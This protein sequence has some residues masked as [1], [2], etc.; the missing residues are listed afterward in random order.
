[1]PSAIGRSNAGPSFLRLAGARFTITRFAGLG[2]EDAYNVDAQGIGVWLVPRSG[3]KLGVRSHAGCAGAGAA[4]YLV[5]AAQR[6]AN[7]QRRRWGRKQERMMN[8]A[9]GDGRAE[10]QRRLIQRS[11]DEEEFRRRLLD[12]PKATIEQEL[13]ARLPEGVQ[14]RAVEETAESVYLVL[15]SASPLGGGVELSDQELEAV[16]GGRGDDGHDCT[17]SP[18][19]WA[20]C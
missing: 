5:L 15:P 11:L 1:M 2:G 12:D 17:L 4:G 16:A 7:A 18:N 13:G 20:E 9:G 6:R 14:V 10:I 19:P 3:G 8:E